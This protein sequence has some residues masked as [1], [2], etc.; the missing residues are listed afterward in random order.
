MNNEAETRCTKCG[1]GLCHRCWWW[2]C[3]GYGLD[4]G[5]YVFDAMRSEAKK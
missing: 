5:G 1:K 2:Q 3:Y 4:N